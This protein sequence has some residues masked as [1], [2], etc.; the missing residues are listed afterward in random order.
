[1]ALEVRMKVVGAFLVWIA[2]FG[3]CLV[4]LR[5]FWHDPRRVPVPVLVAPLAAAV[6]GVGGWRS[7][8]FSFGH[9]VGDISFVL[10]VVSIAVTA[11]L[12][13]KRLQA[14]GARG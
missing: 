1:M 4:W 2:G 12:L 9:W 6:L 3:I 5:A 8:D 7:Y 11:A 13:L 14:A 10:A